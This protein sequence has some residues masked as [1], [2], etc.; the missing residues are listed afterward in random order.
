MKTIKW[1]QSKTI[2]LFLITLITAALTDVKI[3]AVVPDYLWKYVAAVVSF[4]GII[5]RSLTDSQI[6]SK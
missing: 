5:L 4:L 1:W 3:L 2:W 6:R